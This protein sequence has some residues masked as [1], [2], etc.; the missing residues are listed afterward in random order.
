MSSALSV[1]EHYTQTLHSLNETEKI[2]FILRTARLA[3]ACLEAANNDTDRRVA[4]GKKK[5][6]GTT[7]VYNASQQEGLK[8]KYFAAAGVAVVHTPLKMEEQ[9]AL[10]IEDTKCCD[11]PEILMLVEHAVCTACGK[12]VRK[13]TEWVSQVQLSNSYIHIYTVKD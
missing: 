9:T 5:W 10:P 8:R 3:S 12:K 7:K 4:F 6:R 13:L 2:N 11:D 1:H